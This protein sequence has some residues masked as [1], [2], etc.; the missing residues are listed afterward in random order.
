MWGAL[1]VTTTHTNMQQRYIYDPPWQ[2]VNM[3]L[4]G[5]SP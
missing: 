1:M 5:Q 2:M 4:G 3:S